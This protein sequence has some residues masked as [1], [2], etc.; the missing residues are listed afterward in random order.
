MF[1]GT[2][3][4]PKITDNNNKTTISGE[5]F[6]T[7]FSLKMTENHQKFNEMTLKG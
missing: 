2:E 3:S 6:T 5:F 1:N 4:S 7:F